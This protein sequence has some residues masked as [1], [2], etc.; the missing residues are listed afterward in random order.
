[1]FLDIKIPFLSTISLL[2]S[3]N[4]DFC[5]SKLKIFF[6]LREICVILIEKINIREKKKKNNM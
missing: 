5:F 6:L 4:C 2:K 1:M 3:E